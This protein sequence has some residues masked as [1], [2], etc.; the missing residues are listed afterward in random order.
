MMLFGNALV[1]GLLRN[2]KL[3]RTVSF[4]GLGTEA[5][6]E[7]HLDRGG[8]E[9]KF[10]FYVIRATGMIGSTFKRFGKYCG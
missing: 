6:G 8:M 1:T 4:A 5:L 9:W 3:L 10:M 7:A 2:K